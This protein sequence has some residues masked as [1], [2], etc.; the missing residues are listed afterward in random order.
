MTQG[1]FSSPEAKRRAQGSLGFAAARQQRIR[2]ARA[3]ALAKADVTVH[4]GKR[5]LVAP[6]KLALA[7]HA[8]GMTPEHIA[9]S[10]RLP[11]DEVREMLGLGG[12]TDADLVAAYDLVTKGQ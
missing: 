5:P 2:E 9:L 3:A 4:R 1:R 10:T 7:M 6:H 12:A 8:K 11:L